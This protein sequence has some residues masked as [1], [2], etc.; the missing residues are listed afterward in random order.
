MN[1]NNVATGNTKIS[2]LTPFPKNTDT[3][4]AMMKV[5][6]IIP[7]EEAGVTEQGRPRCTNALTY[8]NDD[9]YGV[10][11]DDLPSSDDKVLDVDVVRG[12]P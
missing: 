4:H 9:Q 7:A 10:H 11:P 5:I 12:E 1:A 3:T 2:P 6:V 8:S